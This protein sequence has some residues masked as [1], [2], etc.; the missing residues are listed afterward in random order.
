M[1]DAIC[2]NPSIRSDG[3]LR[4]CIWEHSSIIRDLYTARARDE[5][6]EM[7]CAAQ[8]AELVAPLVRPGDSLLECRLRQWLLLS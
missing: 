3:W 6:E 5:K 2:H 7:T 4:N 8:A 1:K